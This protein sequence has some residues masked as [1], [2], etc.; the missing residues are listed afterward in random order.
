MD[1]V[2]QTTYGCNNGHAAPAAI[3]QGP[4]VLPEAAISLNGYIHVTGLTERIQV[5]ARGHDAAEHHRQP[6]LPV[7]Y[8]SG[9]SGGAAEC[10]G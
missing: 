9:Q 1:T 4:A 6:C 3:P 8:E 7:P 2:A 5:T 10:S